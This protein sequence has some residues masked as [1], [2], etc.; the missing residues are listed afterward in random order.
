MPRNR[1]KPNRI[2]EL[3]SSFQS[4]SLRH[5]PASQAVINRVISG[6][7]DYLMKNLVRIMTDSVKLVEEPEMIDLHLDG[8]EAA[9][10]TQRWMKKYDKRLTAARIKGQDDFQEDFDEMRIKIIAE[11]ATPQFRKEVD[12]RLQVMLDRLS[13]SEDLV[14]LEMVLLLK[15]LL[16]MKNVPW[17][18]C[19]LIIAIY[20][21]AMQ[22]TIQAYEDEKNVYKAVVEAFESEGKED[23]EVTDVFK[24][25]DKLEQIGQKLFSAK[26]GLR[27]RVEQQIWD[28]LDTFEGE[29]AK[30]NIKLDLFTEEELTLPYTRL[31]TELG[32]SFTQAKP[33]EEL[34][35]QVFKAIVD[36]VNTTLT[37]DRYRR[38]CE[39]VQR[40][41]QTWM[42]ERNKWAAAIQGELTWLEKE[43]YKENKFILSVFLGQMARL[44]KENRQKKKR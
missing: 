44:G 27:E 31:R 8:Q 16:G 5:T 3:S 39:D 19:G 25:P 18:L 37:P 29:L 24:S 38:L 15:P 36:A 4:P 41:A 10:I 12:R 34:R 21:R 26:P 28:M 40:T 2:K 11:L 22:Q 43:Q 7:T 13:A 30:G 32:E 42:K 17:G 14:K 35:S 33:S 20:N 1:H 6:G 9:Q 23:F